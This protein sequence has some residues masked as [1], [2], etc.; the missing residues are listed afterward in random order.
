MKLGI[1]LT[2]TIKPN[3]QGGNFTEDERK[4]MYLSTLRYYATVIG[5]D[6]PI[7][8]LENSNANLESIKEEFKDSLNLTIY[9]FRPDNE[10]LYIGFDNS[11]GK[12]FNEYLMIKK[13]LSCMDTPP[14]NQAITHFLKITG[15]YPMLNICSIIGETENRGRDGILFMADVKDTRLY[16][17]IGIDTLSS[18]WGDSRFFMAEIDYYLKNL[19]DC[20]LEMN[21][22]KEGQ[23]AE[24]YILRLSRE[25]RKDPRFKF[26]F[27]TQVR[28]A[29]VSGTLTSEHLHAGIRRQDSPANRI[30]ASARQILRYIFPNIWF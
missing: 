23:W 28:F 10:D 4:D 2:A 20:Y 13:G 1:I 7:Y 25:Y 5:K 11:K 15:R 14:D 26:R 24:H 27:K 30:K 8:L 16:E 18:H 9:Q 22:Y 19:S 12:G 17:M 29:G 21:D 6:Y 3:V